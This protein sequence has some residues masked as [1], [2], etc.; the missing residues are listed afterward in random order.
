MNKWYLCCLWSLFLIWTCMFKAALSF[1]AERVFVVLFCV[2]LLHCVFVFLYINTNSHSNSR[3]DESVFS[4][5]RVQLLECSER[6]LRSESHHMPL[7]F[8]SCLQS[9]FESL[10][11][12]PGCEFISIHWLTWALGSP[13]W[14]TDR[15]GGQMM[16]RESI[17]IH[18]QGLFWGAGWVRV[19]KSHRVITQ[20]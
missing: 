2:V 9:A 12:S 18:H 10:P 7:T 13:I 19:W 14:R 20:C 16:C 6:R 3:G 1:T 5:W 4:D 8:R 15:V 17:T 11:R